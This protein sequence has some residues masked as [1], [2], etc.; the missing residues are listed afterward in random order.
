MPEQPQK[1]PETTQER[2]TPE[3][4]A[5]LFRE[6][7]ASYQTFDDQKPDAIKE[8]LAK[9]TDAL[10]SNLPEG[11]RAEALRQKAYCQAASFRAEIT[12]KL[13]QEAHA[14]GGDGGFAGNELNVLMRISS[15]RNS[16]EAAQFKLKIKNAIQATEK[17][18]ALGLNPQ[19]ETKAQG[20][21][22]QLKEYERRIDAY[23]QEQK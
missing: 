2:L 10:I 8:Q 1:N 13:V 12:Q 4:T 16:V 14:A 9:Y 23:S 19:E 3:K 7:D 15:P 20:M 18:I 11:K 6:A 17:A 21:L 22:E 5:D